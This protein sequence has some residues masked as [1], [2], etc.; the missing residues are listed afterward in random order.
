[1]TVDKMHQG[2]MLSKSDK[3]TRSSGAPKK[4]PLAKPAPPGVE[5]EKESHSSTGANPRKAH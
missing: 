2:G 4:E 1:V 3:D 5:H